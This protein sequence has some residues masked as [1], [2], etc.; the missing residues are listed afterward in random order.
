MQKGDLAGRSTDYRRCARSTRRN[1]EAA[2]NLG[3]AL[4]Q[5]DD[6]AAAEIE[7]RKAMALDPALPEAPFTLGV[8]LWQTGRATKPL[9]QFRDA[10]ARKPDYA[11]AHYMIGTV[12]KQQGALDDAI[13]QFR[14]IAVP[15]ALRRGA[16]QPRPGAGQQGDPA[17]RGGGAR[18]GR[19][20]N[21]RT[22]DAQASTFAV[23]VG[24][25][26]LKAND[27]G[28]HRAVPRGHPSRRRQPAGALSARARPAPRGARRRP[29]RTSTRRAGSRRTS[30]AGGRRM[31]TGWRAGLLVVTTLA[32]QAVLAF[33]RASGPRSRSP[34]R[35]PTRPVRRG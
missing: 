19:A 28:R 22:A 13:A 35:S 11:D 25:Q 33:A 5:Q 14:D 32:S 4:K 1:A 18:R 20:L 27:R 7:L 23:S 8:V 30:S 12:L 9:Q 10:I 16:P 29:S 6:F 24:V 26:K 15:A 31:M 21:R 17:A 2:Y 34:F 3:L